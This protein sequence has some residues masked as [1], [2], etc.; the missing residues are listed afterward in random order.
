MKYFIN[1]DVTFPITSVFNSE[2]I[3]VF[4]Q[5][6]NK[7]FTKGIELDF[8]DSCYNPVFNLKDIED[9]IKNAK[10][11][12]IDEAITVNKYNT[13]NRIDVIDIILDKI[14]YNLDNEKNTNEY[15]RIAD[16]LDNY[17]DKISTKVN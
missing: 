14:C 17:N 16:I 9:F 13:N 1:H 4:N 6:K 7:Y 3:E 12:S 2:M 15:N 11:I 8:D 10:D 5:Y